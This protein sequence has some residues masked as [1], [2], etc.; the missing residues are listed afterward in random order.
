M[1]GLGTIIISVGFWP[2]S[3]GP[4]SPSSEISEINVPAPTASTVTLFTSPPV[5]IVT[6]STS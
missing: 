5:S 2:V 4:V 3:P 6:W 1:S